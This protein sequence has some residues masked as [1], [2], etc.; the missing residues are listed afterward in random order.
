MPECFC[1]C[2]RR[3]PRLAPRRRSVNRRGGQVVAC[4]A[5]V[6]RRGGREYPQLAEWFSEGERIAA[7]LAGVVHGELDRRSLDDGAVREWQE[8]GR[9]IAP[10]QQRIEA[11]LGRASRL[12]GLSSEDAV[13]AVVRGMRERGLTAEEAIAAVVR[14][15]LR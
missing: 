5:E 3:V 6:E 7:T 9:A 8:K 2:G 14:R 1:G 15:E 10:S 4:L 11:M 12:S 13:A